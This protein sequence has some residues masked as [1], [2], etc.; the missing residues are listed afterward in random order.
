MTHEEFRLMLGVRRSSV[1]DAL[2]RL[3]EERAVRATRGRVVV[4]DRA[5]LITLAE[6]TYGRPEREYGR[7]MER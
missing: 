3:E 6:G 7:L 4:L 5:T 1:T 2:H